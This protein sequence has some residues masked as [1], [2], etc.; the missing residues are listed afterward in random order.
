MIKRKKMFALLISASENIPFLN[1]SRRLQNTY[2]R[3]I[4]LINSVI[5]CYFFRLFKGPHA[6]HQAMETGNGIVF[7]AYHLMSSV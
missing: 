5:M 3:L 7:A 1:R 2:V 6:G 4:C